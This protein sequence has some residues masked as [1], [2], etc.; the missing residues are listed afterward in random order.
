[1][2]LLI[3]KYIAIG[4]WDLKND[5]SSRERDADDQITI[6]KTYSRLKYST[7]VMLIY[8]HYSM[9][10]AYS[11]VHSLESSIIQQLSSLCTE[12]QWWHKLIQEDLWPDSLIPLTGRKNHHILNQTLI[13]LSVATVYV[14]NKVHYITLTL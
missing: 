11:V 4:R 8:K 14:W 9:T 10:L 7:I 3:M 13:L 6:N 2:M 1:M 12:Q 5:C